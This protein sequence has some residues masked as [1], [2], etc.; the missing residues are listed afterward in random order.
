MKRIQISAAAVTC[1]L[2]C[3]FCP[4]VTY[5]EVPKWVVYPDKEWKVLT[6]EEAGIGDVAAWNRWVEATRKT[7][8]GA[9]F[10]GEDHRENK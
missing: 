2:F 6:A 1:H 9:S 8:K 4:A 5:A 7:A 10:Q 3:C